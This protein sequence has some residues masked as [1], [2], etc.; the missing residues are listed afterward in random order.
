MSE[1]IFWPSHGSLGTGRCGSLVPQG[2]RFDGSGKGAVNTQKGRH[3]E[4]PPLPGVV[5][6]DKQKKLL[7]SGLPVRA[8]P[9]RKEVNL[10]CSANS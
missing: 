2:T 10:E 9:G 8:T 4:F 1:P 3:S 7:S 5:L 6:A